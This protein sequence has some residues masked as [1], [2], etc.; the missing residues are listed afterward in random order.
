MVSQCLKHNFACCTENSWLTF[1]MDENHYKNSHGVYIYTWVW[2]INQER[3][4]WVHIQRLY[5]KLSTLTYAFLQSGQTKHFNLGAWTGWTFIQWACN[6]LLQVLQRRTGLLLIIF[7]ILHISRGQGFSSKSH[8][9]L[10]MALPNGNKSK[11]QKT[12]EK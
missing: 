4:E 7:F 3:V 10:Q 12:G 1:T 9:R 8:I 6:H 2:Y 5:R 11:D